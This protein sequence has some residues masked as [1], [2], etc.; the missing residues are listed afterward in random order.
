[1]S[2]LKVGTIQNVS[3]ASAST[4]EEIHSG[5]AKAWATFQAVTGATFVDDFNC[6]S[7]TDG[8]TGVFTVNF[9]NALNNSNYCVVEG[10]TSYD[11]D[12]KMAGISVDARSSGGHTIALK[13]T[14]AVKI[15]C[16]AGGGTEFD[17][18]QGYLA[19]FVS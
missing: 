9:S 18:A 16:T 7:I 17:P 3:G 15:L 4:P 1:M 19:I 12:Q 6:S 10:A 8:G 2:T 5:R 14:T 11:S 13:T